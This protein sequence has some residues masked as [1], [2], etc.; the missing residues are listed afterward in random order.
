MVN[1]SEHQRRLLSAT[2]ICAV[3][4]ALY[5]CVSRTP[6]QQVSRLHHTVYALVTWPAFAALTSSPAQNTPCAP[7]AVTGPLVDDFA[8]L[9]Q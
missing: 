5:A 8:N 7:I 3:V 4:A 9:L 2:A 1:P 6:E